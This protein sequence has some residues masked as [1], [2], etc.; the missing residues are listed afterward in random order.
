MSELTPI[1][2]QVWTGPAPQI[3]PKRRP[4]LRATVTKIGLEHPAAGTEPGPWCVVAVYTE[5]TKPDGSRA[6]PAESAQF[7]I[8]NLRHFFRDKGFEF[9]RDGAVVFARHIGTPVAPAM[10][11]EPPADNPLATGGVVTTPQPVAALPAEQVIPPAPT[12]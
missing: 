4:S 12:A 10:H 1:P 11:V 6:F 5:H 9:G 3:S 2:G 8:N 7:A